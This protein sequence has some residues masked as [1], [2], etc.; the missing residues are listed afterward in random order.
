MELSLL[1]QRLGLVLFYVIIATTII[2]PIATS[3]FIPYEVDMTNHLAAI[4]QAKLALLEG[5]FPLRV[6]PLELHGWRYPFYQF[7]APTT[8][9]FTG[10]LA[11]LFYYATAFNIYKI[12][13]IIALTLGAACIYHLA[14]WFVKSKPAS[15]L[16]GVV[17]ITVPYTIVNV[18][19]IG[20]FNEVIAYGLLP[21]I[22]LSTLKYFLH[23]KSLTGFLFTSVLWYAL[24]TIHILV[25]L[26]SSIFVALFLIITTVKS[27]KRWLHLFAVG[28]AYLFAFALAAWYIGPVVLLNKYLHA[29][30]ALKE[31]RLYPID[32]A[33]LLTPSVY[34]SP[35]FGTKDNLI[36][37]ISV[38]RPAIGMPIVFAAGIYIYSLIYGNNHGR[39]RIHFWLLPL[40]V[41][42]LLSVLLIIA[43]QNFWEV[44]P[45]QFKV[46]QYPWRLLAQTSWTG[47]LLFAWAIVWLFKN[48]LDVKHVVIATFLVMMS[49]SAWYNI[50][51][52]SYRTVAEALHNPHLG[53]NA[54]AYLID[55][56]RYSKFI[57]V[58]NKMPIMFALQRLKP[59]KEP[60]EIAEPH[61]ISEKIY[62]TSVQPFITVEGTVNPGMKAQQ[63]DIYINDKVFASAKFNEGAFT[64]QVPIPK[65]VKNNKPL[66]FKLAATKAKTMVVPAD[67]VM[68]GGFVK[69][70][71]LMDVSK[72]QPYCQQQGIF[73]QCKL[74]VPKG[75]E[76]LELP[77]VYYPRMLEVK[78]DNK[79]SAYIGVLNA[80][81]LLA[82]VKPIPGKI[83]TISFQFTGML[84]ANYIS[85][86]AW[87]IWFILLAYGQVKRRKTALA[88]PAALR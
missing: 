11:T 54:Q 8:Y 16:A 6:M 39:K 31:A 5:Q 60:L 77:L 83:N 75:T 29:C 42:F 34:N 57:Q 1:Q 22:I 27:K 84:G 52:I 85:Q 56:N 4:A 38:F 70:E 17:Y 51:A 13:L 20:A 66:S 36:N 82:G 15:L 43:P 23:P 48:K 2:S 33:N 40:F 44:L 59:G 69:A 50:P 28:G 35:P 30:S 81:T 65:Y 46:I 7:Y 9:L 88:A 3:L 78:V 49:T 21:L 37:I 25:F 12:T 86:C 53:D 63:L 74:Y 72:V 62:Q 24:I 76:L 45:L 32:L 10:I 68:L 87:A 55:A 26:S 19:H 80:S 58:I 73:T 47:A 41:L 67:K 61:F 14:Y 79:P 71:Q 64:W 18:N